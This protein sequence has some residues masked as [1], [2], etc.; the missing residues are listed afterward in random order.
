MFVIQKDLCKSCGVCRDLCPKSAVSDVAPYAIDAEL[1]VE[2]GLCA[3]NCPAKAIVR[4]AMTEFLECRHCPVRCH[5]PFGQLGAC[6]RYCNDGGRL[7]RDAELVPMPDEPPSADPGAVAISR[8]LVTGIGA[9]TLYPNPRPAPI[10]VQKRVNGIDVVT[11]VTEAPLT[12]SGVKVKIDTDYFIGRETAVVRYKGHPVGHVTTEEYGSKLLSIGGANVLT[13]K[14]GCYAAQAVVDLA[15]KRRVTLTVEDTTLELQAGQPPVINGV[16]AER[17]RPAC[18]S[19]VGSVGAYFKGLVDEVIIL[20]GAITGLMTAH[21]GSEDLDFPPTGIV[22]VGTCS[23]PGR[24]LGR[25]GDGWGGTSVHHASEAIASIDPA[26]AWPGLTLLVTEPNMERM[27]LLRLDERLEP[28]EI[29][30]PQAVHEAMDKIRRRAQPSRVTVL[31]MGGAGGGVRFSLT[32]ESPQKVWEEVNR[33][34]I[35]LTVGGADAYIWPGGGITYMVDVEKIP[36][37]PFSWSPTPSTISPIEMTM[38]R[39]V[40]DGI[41]GYQDAVTDF[42]QIGTI[43]R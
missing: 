30:I 4:E 17:M 1:C 37:E 5:I 7:V 15:N 19:Q 36:G 31:Y 16:R 2:C 6:Q 27:A 40:Y 20:D 12:F 8:P 25:K 38:R 18:G 43:R 39:E 11:A 34:N 29:V 23:T 28:V 9:G 35:R 41:G 13:G 26:V 42:S 24:Y 32:P 21:P 14:H 3:K 33:G 22:P 10:I